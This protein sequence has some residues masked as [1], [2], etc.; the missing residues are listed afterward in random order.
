MMPDSVG[1]P[2]AIPAAR[3]S[4]L[5]MTLPPGR[6]STVM[7]ADAAVAVEAEAVVG[8]KTSKPLRIFGSRC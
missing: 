3:T 1:P 8:T 7:E 4:E 5:G 2:P 6:N